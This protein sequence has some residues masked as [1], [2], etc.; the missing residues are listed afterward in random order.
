MVKAL[1]RFDQNEDFDSLVDAMPL[2]PLV[3]IGAGASVASGY[4]SWTGLLKDLQKRIHIAS[5]VS[6]LS[7][8]LQV[9]L[10]ELGD[11]LW[12]AEELVLRLGEVEFHKFIEETFQAREPS[13]AGSNLYQALAAIEFRHYITTNYDPCIEQAMS[14][15]DRTYRVLNWRDSK[16][17][18]SFF[19][20]LSDP[21]AIA[22]II[23]LHGRYST[24]RDIVFT[25][26]SYRIYLDDIFYRRLLAI[27]MTQPVVFIGFSMTDPE[28]GQLLRVARATMH[29]GAARHFGIFGYRTTEERDLIKRRMDGKYGVRAVFYRIFN[30]EAGKEDHGALVDLLR[31]FTRPSVPVISADK[32]HEQSSGVN[33]SEALSSCIVPPSSPSNTIDPHKG[34]F[35]GRAKTDNRA[36]SV[37]DIVIVAEDAYVAFTLV[38]ASTGDPPLE[39]EVRFQLHPTFHRDDYTEIA[40]DGQSSS[41]VAAA[42]GAFTV[43]V[44]AD[45]G[46]TKLELD[47][48]EID[49]FPTWFRER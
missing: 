3:F 33:A 27:F 6:T 5:N 40:K 17:V 23:Y 34:R 24:P 44:T 1:Q 2:R 15:V 4:P 43:G 32:K 48:S 12:H 10:D 45:G 22:S 9:V 46:K 30:D 38:V 20:S 39:G 41:H 11:P 18:G 13:V 37:E 21:E 16:D 29:T 14:V 25:E 19:R 47:L 28:L 8:K 31:H 35:G 26:S 7:P 49:Q 36:L 42:Y